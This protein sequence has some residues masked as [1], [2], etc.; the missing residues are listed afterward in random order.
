MRSSGMKLLAAGVLVTLVG[1]EQD[2][3]DVGFMKASAEME[4]AASARSAIVGQPA[5]DFAL[6]DQDGQAVSLRGLRGKWVVLY[7]YPQDDTPG[8]ACQA[9]E[10]TA[11]L[12]SFRDMNATVLGVS[13]DNPASHRRFIEKYNLKLVLL[14][15]PEHAV[16]RR[17]GAWATTALGDK[18]YGRVVRTTV[19]I[20]PQGTIRHHWPEVLPTGHAERVRTKLAALQA[21]GH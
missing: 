10:F 7:F 18:Q 2:T 11:L 12:W 20:D 15:D 13:P 3:N 8:C 19:I 16:M 21:V 6:P 17:Y 9:T 5:P 1:C 4:Q 14:S